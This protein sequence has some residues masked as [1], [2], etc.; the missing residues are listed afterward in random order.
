VKIGQY[1]AKIW[2]KVCGLIFGA[3]PYTVGFGVK[4]HPNEGTQ[5]SIPFSSLLTALYN[6]IDVIDEAVEI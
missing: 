2:T 1:L 5:Y 4:V 6:M 3:S